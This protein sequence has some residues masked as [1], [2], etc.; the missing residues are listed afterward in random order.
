M[1]SARSILPGHVLLVGVDVWAKPETFGFSRHS[2]A[3]K[4]LM[5][6]VCPGVVATEWIT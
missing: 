6:A 1:S 2:F 5:A 4:S 3:M